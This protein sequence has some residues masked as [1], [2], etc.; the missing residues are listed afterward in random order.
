MTTYQ[1]IFFDLD[2]TLLFT[3][4]EVWSLYPQWARECGLQVSSTAAHQVERFAHRYFASNAYTDDYA[5]YGES[6]F[7]LHYLKRCLQAMECVG[8]VDAATPYV[9]QR[10]REV[11]RRRVVPTETRALLARLHTRGYRLGLV[12]NR[13]ADEMPEVFEPLDLAPYFTVIVTSSDAPMPKPDRAMFD[14]ALARMGCAAAA[15]VHVGDNPYADVAGACN[16]GIRPILFD[17]KGL[18]PEVT[19]LTIQ[20][21]SQLGQHLEV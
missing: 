19:C 6:G 7:R 9:W 11:P 2:G 13:R 5:R 21:L 1:A 14:L 16:T 12:T 8:D 18:F 15:A 3:E 17:P 20:T 4:P 10:F